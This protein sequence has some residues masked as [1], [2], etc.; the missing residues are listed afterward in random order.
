MIRNPVSTRVQ[1]ETAEAK[2]SAS[3]PTIPAAVFGGS[4]YVAGELLRLLALHPRFE[5][6]TIFSTS[7]AGERV[8]S[9]FPHLA[10]TKL[11]SLLF[12]AEENAFDPSSPLV[13]GSGPLAVFTATPHGAAA[14]IVAKL[15]AARAAA[16]RARGAGRSPEGDQ[17]SSLFHL[18]DL[19]ADFRFADPNEWAAIYGKP[20]HP[21]P[22]LI[23]QFTCAV[24]EHVAP[25]LSP[26]TQHAA[27]PGCFTTAAVCAAWPFF[28]LGLVEGDVFV[29]A[30]TGSSGSGKTPAANTHHPDRH[31]TLYAYSALSHRHEAEMRHLIGA[32]CRGCEPDVEFVPHSGPF[33]RGIH[34]TLRMSL[35]EEMTAAD[36]VE[37]VNALYEGGAASGAGRGAGPGS[38]DR[39]FVTA[40]ATPPKLTEVIGTNRCRLGLATRGRTLVVTSVLDNLTKGASGGAVQWMNRLFG[41]PDSTGLELPGLGWF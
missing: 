35:R 19:S 36:L 4:G 17:H 1:P 15:F 31:S 20:V 5:P 26:M 41:M 29:S 32:A 13:A 21:A 8:T 28:K 22:D 40:S 39:S 38:Q 10:G 30:V 12:T 24:P 11:D 23:P 33:V 34:A 25:L 9:A 7:Q 14:P 2:T 37:R 27:Q 18:V 3:T 16:T 6:T